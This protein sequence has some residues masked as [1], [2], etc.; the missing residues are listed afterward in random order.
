MVVSYKHKYISTLWP[1]NSSPRY[2]PKRNDNICS[3]KD[4]HMNAPSNFIYSILKLET[5]QMFMNRNIDKLWLYS[6]K[7]DKLLMYATTWVN[8]KII[9]FSERS[10]INRQKGVHTTGFIC[11]Q[12]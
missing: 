1:V 4:L 8:H 10:H 3:Q 6:E 9:I 12:S 7:R 11:M 5:A 2:F